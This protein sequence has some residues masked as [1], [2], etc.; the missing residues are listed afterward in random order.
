MPEKLPV[1]VTTQSFQLQFLRASVSNTFATHCT[2]AVSAVF[3]RTMRVTRSETDYEKARVHVGPR[4]SGE[5]E[6]RRRKGGKEGV[7]RAIRRY[8]PPSRAASPRVARIGNNSANDMC[9]Y[10][11]L[12]LFPLPVLFSFRRHL[13]FNDCHALYIDKEACTRID[14]CYVSIECC[15]MR[16]L[17]A[18]PRISINLILHF[19]CYHHNQA[20]KILQVSHRGFERACPRLPSRREQEAGSFRRNTPR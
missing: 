9:T 1:E 14:Q 17:C 11:L 20:S 7:A 15:V 19:L 6:P 18:A 5:R 3:R 12:N 4:N 8:Y 2:L 13:R 16:K 10:R